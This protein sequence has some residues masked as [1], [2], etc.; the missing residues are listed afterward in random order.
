L[1]PEEVAR[2]ALY[3]V[4]DESAGVTGIAHLVNGGI[5]AVAEYSSAWTDPRKEHR[6]TE[7]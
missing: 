4:S 1:T 5:L 3:L 2:A 6:E 7:A